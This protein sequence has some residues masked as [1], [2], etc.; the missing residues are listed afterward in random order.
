MREY[1]GKV[2]VEKAPHDINELLEIV[3]ILRGPNGCSWD[4]AQTLDSM[5]TCLINESQEVID[6]IDKKDYEN[7]CEELGDLLLQVVMN[8]EIA[9]ETDKFDFSAVVQTVCEKLIRRHPHVFGDVKRPTTPEES[10]A[11]WKSVKQK[12]KEEKSKKTPEK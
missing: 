7:L 5:K 4:G 10:L 1:N 3:K 11:L 6:A 12:E 9:S 2:Y 8:A